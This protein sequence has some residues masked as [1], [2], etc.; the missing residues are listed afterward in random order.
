VRVVLLAV[1]IAGL[2]APALAHP[3]DPDWRRRANV[4][5]MELQAERDRA[6]ASARETRA[7]EERARTEARM[8][9]LRDGELAGGPS[10]SGMTWR[11]MA[12]ATPL[13]PLTPAAVSAAVPD[14]TGDAA[15]MDALMAEAMARSTARVRAMTGDRPR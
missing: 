4:E 5:A 1:L 9:T 11:P 12:T 13:P 10:A 2:A 3:Y 7:R 8:R 14:L 15:R 6:A